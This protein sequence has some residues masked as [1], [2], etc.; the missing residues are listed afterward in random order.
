MTVMPVAYG[1]YI[2]SPYGP[3]WGTM[4][5]G[6][7]YGRGGGSGNH[8]IYAVKDGT[9]TRAGTAQGFGQWITIDHPASNG[10]GETVYGH[11]IPEVRVGQKVVEGQRIGRIN[12][13]SR[14]NGGVAPHL[15]FEWHRFV[16]SPP[17]KDRLDPAVMLKGARWIGASTTP[18]APPSVRTVPMDVDLSARF[19]FGNPRK[20]ALLQGVCIHTTENSETSTAKAVA[21]WQIRSQSG[22]YHFI[23]DSKGTRVRCNTDDWRTWSTGNKG[24]D[25]LLHVSFVAYAHWD[26]QKWLS[27]DRM[28]RAGA[29]VVAHW[30]TKYRIPVKH[31]DVKGLPGITT[32]DATRVW[33]GT[34]HTDPGRGFPWD[35][36]LGYVNDEMK[37]IN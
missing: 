12:P 21:E 17:G 27:Q 34:D 6:T 25:V 8:P 35:V 19:G 22:S 3:R 16:W 10:G 15:H 13:D 36:F 9:V 5:W 18:A 24:N 2:T 31:T 7:D 14:T 26:R 37:K 29:S 28:L 32:H 1:F 11:V 4:H 23:V 30:C 33:G 20:V